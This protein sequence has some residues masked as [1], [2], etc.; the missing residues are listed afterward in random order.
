MG[1]LDQRS[2]SGA[3]FPATKASG[4]LVDRQIDKVI[5]AD[6]GVEGGG[7]TIYGSK[8]EGIWSFWTQCTSMDL[9]ENDDEVWRSW[10]SQPVSSLDLVMP[11]D[12]PVYFPSKIHPDF[13]GWFRANYDTVRALLPED[14]LR[15][16]AKH[17]HSHWLK[18]LDLSR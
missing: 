1:Y 5:V 13:V 7:T 9:D 3:S 4:N 8:S 16:Q 15:Y 11:Q 14:Q 2:P 10:S 6:I 17:R 18:V 12:W